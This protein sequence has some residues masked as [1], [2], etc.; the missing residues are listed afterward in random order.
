M[1]GGSDGEVKATAGESFVGQNYFDVVL[2]GLFLLFDLLL[3]LFLEEELLFV[4]LQLLLKPF[5]LYVILGHGLF[6]ILDSLFHFDD[7]SLFLL[8]VLFVDWD[9][10]LFL[11]WRLSLQNFLQLLK[12]FFH[13]LDVLFLCLDL[14]SLQ[15]ES[16]LDGL[17]FRHEL[18]SGWVSSFQL[19]PPVYIHG[20]LNFLRQGLNLKLAFCKFPTQIMNLCPQIHNGPI[21][22]PITL[23]LIHMRRYLFLLRLN[24]NNP[25]IKNKILLS[26]LCLSLSK[27]RLINLYLFI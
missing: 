23:N 11:D 7:L 25:K 10:P 13:F 1:F 21:L 16:F 17:Y 6:I 24:L 20:I 18:I 3:P 22:R 15:N 14:L 9:H 19:S 5:Q 27:C 12:F 2:L 26:I 8:E 4:V